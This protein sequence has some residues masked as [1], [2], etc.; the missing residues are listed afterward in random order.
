VQVISSGPPEYDVVSPLF[1]SSASPCVHLLEPISSIR[2]WLLFMNR[3]YVVITDSAAGIRRRRR[4][5]QPVLVT[6]G[7]T[8]RPEGVEAGVARLGRDRR[9]EERIVSETLRLLRDFAEHDRMATGATR[10]AMAP[11]RGR[12]GRHRHHL[13]E[14]SAR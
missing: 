12:C 10:T 11:R 1:T 3:A 13:S 5:A 2:G 8:E 9:K 4:Q 6:R 7:F 14:T